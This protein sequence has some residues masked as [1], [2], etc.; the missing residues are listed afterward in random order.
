MSTLIFVLVSVGAGFFVGVPLTALLLGNDF[1]D[2]WVV[3]PFMGIAG[4]TLAAQNLIYLDIPLSVSAPFLWALGMLGWS[5][6]LFRGRIGEV[7]HKVPRALLTTALLVYGLQGLGLWVASAR[8]Y[9]G[10]G[11]FDQFNYTA[12]SQ[13]LVDYPFSTQ[14][15]EITGQPYLIKAVTLKGDRIG[16][17]IV[18]GFLA[19]SVSADAKT[20]FEP[21]IL[22]SPFLIVLGG[23]VMARKLGLGRSLALVAGAI[24]GMLPAVSAVH[25]ES[26]LSQ[27]LVMPYLLVWPALASWVSVNPNWRRLLAAGIFLAGAVSLYTELAVLFVGCAA[28][29]FFMAGM[30]HERKPESLVATIAILISFSAVLN[31]G[32]VKG[33]IEI[34]RRLAWPNVLAAIYPYAFSSEGLLR[35][36]LGDWATRLTPIVGLLLVTVTILGLAMALAGFVLALVRKRDGHAA[37][38]LMLAAFPLVARARGEQFGYQYYKILLTVSPMIPI[39]VASLLGDLSGSG[40]RRKSVFSAVPLLLGTLGLA[41]SVVAVGAAMDMA[42]RSGRGGTQEETGR[43]GAFKL[44]SSSSKNIQDVLLSMGGGQLLIAWTD[45]FYSGSYINAWLAY[46]GRHNIVYLSNPLVSD[47]N[48]DAW[49]PEGQGPFVPRENSYALTSPSNSCRLRG[50]SIRLDWHDGPYNLWRISGGDWVI[51]TQVSNP[52]GLE[53][54]AG[55]EFFWVGNGETK[56]ELFSGRSGVAMLA[57]EFIPGPSLPDT[58]LRRVDIVDGM[59]ASRVWST[60]DGNAIAVSV[61]PGKN[62]VVLRSIDSPTVFIQPNGDTRPLLLGVRGLCIS[63]LW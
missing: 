6:L 31:L 47:T 33:I 37:A 9:V 52:N 22:L 4:I 35:L 39:G 12:M 54:L 1:E 29:C 49:T 27:A 25:L 50:A 19:T 7:R 63:D 24:G 57:A 11:W 41:V 56:L 46:F 2:I 53:V 17:S 62:E 23:N 42:Y 59:G 44:L 34:T 48:V 45:D 13:F 55:K 36:W 8:Y 58:P 51:L 18:Q 38:V 32:F 61:R 40:H 16:A 15:D 60:A 5:W 43:G 20:L 3:A 10:R 26:F 30:R 14:V 28:V 21:T